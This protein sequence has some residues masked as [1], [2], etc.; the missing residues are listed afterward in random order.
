M[1]LKHV[2]LKSLKELDKP[3]SYHQIYLHILENNYYDFS[4]S[5][6]PENSISAALGNLVREGDMRV[7]RIYNG[8]HSYLYRY[9]D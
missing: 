4:N 3:V 7:K 9:V 2:V 1:M 6:T 8:E 5:K